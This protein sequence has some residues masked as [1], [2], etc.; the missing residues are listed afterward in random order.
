M[1]GVLLMSHGRMAE[2]MLDSSKLFVGEDIP[3]IQALC[4]MP[5]D[6]PEEFDQR[7]KEAAAQV[8]DGHGVIAMCDLLGGTPS[9]RSVF[10][11]N[12]RLQVI[13]GMNFTML[14]ELLGRRLSV[15]DLKD[16]DLNDLMKV[17]RDG[18]VNLNDFFKETQSEGADE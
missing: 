7:I 3:Q 9:N 8:D 18:I 6:N 4:L 14:L 11:M 13:T 16:I 15:E 1:I 17:G 12:D 5:S 2:G 10:V